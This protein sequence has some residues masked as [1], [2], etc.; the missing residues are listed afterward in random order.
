MMDELA[1]RILAALLLFVS[2][3]AFAQEADTKTAPNS[4]TMVLE[5]DSRDTRQQ[6]QELLRRL[7][8]DVGKVLKLD[9]SLWANDKY[10]ANYPALA[11]FVAA[12]P[13][14]A[15]SPN[16]Y[17]DSVWI[18]SDRAPETT[19]FRLWNRM[20]ETISIF[21]AFLFVAFVLTWLIR[22]L[23]EQRRWTRLS[24]TQA[25]VHNKLLD[26]FASNEELLNYIQTPAG[27]RFLESAPIPLDQP[28][29]RPVSAPIGRILWS[30][31]AGLVTLAG[32]IGLRFVSMNVQHDA[33]EPLAAL[34]SLGIA[35]GIGLVVSAGASFLLS[36]RLGLWQDPRSADTTANE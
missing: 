22:T 33:A 3:T 10:L 14:V 27:R 12:H 30:V 18:P 28:P 8:P 11:A 35:I 23:I 13:D 34:G 24:K 21:G 2:C 25:D 19:T 31:Q 17:L 4:T 36:R 5:S 32:G 29:T 1:R 15:H 9:P 7:P 6:F 20:L 16:F 26:R